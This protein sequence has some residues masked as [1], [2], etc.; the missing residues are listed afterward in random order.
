MQSLA[1][2]EGEFCDP[3]SALKTLYQQQIHKSKYAR[4]RE[5]LKRREDW[6]ETVDRYINF[7][8]EHLEKSNFELN[9]STIKKLKSSI[10][11]LEVMPSMRALMTAGKAL[12]RDN[13]AGYNCSFTAIDRI[14]AFDEAMY[15][16]MCGVGVGFSVENKYISK[17]DQIPSILLNTDKIISVEDSR[18]GWASAFRELITELY[19]GNICK[20]DVSKV[21]PAGAR[22]ETFGGLASGPEP[23]EALFEYTINIFKN[24]QG[25]KL[26]SI[27]AHGIMCK[28]ADIVIV[29]GVRRSALLSLSDLNDA[30]MRNSKSGT[31]WESNPEFALSNN[32][33]CY[34]KTPTKEEFWFEWESL[35]KS[36]SGERGIVNREGLQKKSQESGRRISDHE[37]GLNPCAEIILR[38][39]QFCNLTEV[40]IRE[41][42][43]FLG[44]KEKI[45]NAT[46]LGVIQ[47]SFT[48]FRYLSPEWKK[49]S[50]EERL[51][52]VSLTGIMDHPILSDLDNAYTIE[53][54]LNE[55]RE[56]AIKIAKEWSEKL[57]INMPTAITCV[58]PSGTVSQ[59]VD[60]S[61]GMHARYSDYYLRSNRLSKLDPVA[62]LLYI[63]GVPCEDELLHPDTTWV[64]Y[65]PIK[66]PSTSVKVKHINALDQLRLWMLYAEYWCEHKPSVT[67][68]VKE[69]E[70]QEVGEFVYDNFDKMSGVS[71]LPHTDHCYEQ[72]PYMEISENQY[73]EFS[74]KMPKTINWDLLY[75]LEK[76]DS[77]NGSRELACVAG[78]CEI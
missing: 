10:F 66:S 25:R 5:D 27:E 77:T 37:F 6:E 72:A 76:V 69:P 51:L 30:E 4:W 26:K 59:L 31:W 24:A 42:D 19:K 3:N 62:N 50:E 18:V 15:I 39:K 65:Y 54:W 38:N 36:K 57:N 16:L 53:I 56:A 45:E 63:S 52:G 13:A 34:E 46:I 43:S 11:N 23:L 28:I 33:A 9:K 20:W 70:W 78:A 71:F 60:S 67:V 22:L 35:I 44:I 74:A 12:E 40:V 21:R 32:S 55:F 41:S 49:N 1:L 7:I 68:Y 73:L 14:E 48:D 58:K 61:S 2:Q 29:G 8:S 47:S 64:F 75:D 17:L